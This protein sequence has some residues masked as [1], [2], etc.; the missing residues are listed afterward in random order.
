MKLKYLIIFF[1]G[2]FLILPLVSALDEELIKICGGDEQ[3]LIGCIGDDELVFLSGG[4]PSGPGT[5]TGGGGGTVT[6]PGEFYT[7]I[8]FDIFGS[9]TGDY[10]VTNIQIVDATPTIFLDALPTTKQSLA[11]G[12]SNKLLWN[13]SL[14]EVEPL[15]NY[16]QPVTFWINISGMIVGYIF[17]EQDSI[18]LDVTEPLEG[19]QESTPAF[20]IFFPDLSFFEEMGFPKEDIIVFKWVLGIIAI[21][22][23][24]LLIRRRTKKK[25]EKKEKERKS[26]FVPVLGKKQKK[27]RFIDILIILVILFLILSIFLIPSKEE[28]IEPKIVVHYYKN[29]VE[30]ML[31]LAEASSSY[32]LFYYREQE[33]SHSSEVG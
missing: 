16:I 7:H 24:I 30:I 21:I 12:E 10:P 6:P 31:P 33:Y 26:I 13:S 1:F 9:N 22:L 27:S 5:G 19:G 32:D 14:I 23:I 25:I 28:K 20:A 2:I 4:E 17:Y 8:S 18:D 15:I 29:G 11:V 3:L